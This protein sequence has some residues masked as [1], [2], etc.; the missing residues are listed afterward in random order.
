MDE[1]ESSANSR[2]WLKRLIDAN[3]YQA[4]RIGETAYEIPIRGALR[5][6]HIRTYLRNGWLTVTAYVMEVP[7][8]V[9]Q[10]SAIMGRM[11]ELND[12]MP[13]AKFTKCNGSLTVD[14]GYREEHVGA[15][16]F[17]NL[18]G[19]LHGLCEKHYPELFR[20]ASGDAALTEL[21][22]AY[23]RSNPA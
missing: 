8:S 21:Q 2:R 14:A 6:W 13:L 20:I 18:V 3:K 22:E 4:H 19:L 15:E 11:M 12:A 7:D 10:R 16:A 1:S 9:S 23:E 5:D 17:G